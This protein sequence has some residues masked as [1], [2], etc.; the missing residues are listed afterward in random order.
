MAKWYGVIG[1]GKHVE[2]VPGVYEEEITERKYYGEIIQNTRMLQ[3]AD[4]LND[5][6]N[7]AN[8]FSI[9][10][11]PF[12]TENFHM[13]RY[14]EFMGAKWKITRVRVQYPRLILTVG[15]V[16]NGEQA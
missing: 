1:F 5:D 2:T 10:A 9:I 6:I 12:A 3:S 7:I 13:L 14:I 8:E 11:D 16:Y 4:Q 15:G